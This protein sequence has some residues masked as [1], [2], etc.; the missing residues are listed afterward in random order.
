MRRISKIMDD[1]GREKRDLHHWDP[2]P[3]ILGID[4]AP[5]TCA[6][7]AMGQLANNQAM[8]VKPDGPG[9]PCS[10][11]N[12]MWPQEKGTSGHETGQTGGTVCMALGL[13]LSRPT[14]V[15]FSPAVARARRG[16]GPP[17]PPAPTSTSSFLS[18][19]QRRKR[20]SG[21]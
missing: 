12:N 11:T 2:T 10:N 7:M 1:R 3:C 17:T 4:L 16:F 9:H 8:P 19:R 15:T 14:F 5:V 13:A 20:V 18:A 6:D 21:G